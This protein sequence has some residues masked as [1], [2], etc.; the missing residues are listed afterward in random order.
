MFAECALAVLTFTDTRTLAEVWIL[1]GPTLTQVQRQ[2][3]SQSVNRCSLSPTLGCYPELGVLYT[4]PRPSQPRAYLHG[5]Q[6][7]RSPV[8]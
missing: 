6:P 5:I 4:Q 2:T 7:S 1:M 3:C 8:P